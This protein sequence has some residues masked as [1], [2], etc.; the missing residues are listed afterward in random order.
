MIKFQVQKLLILVKLDSVTTLTL[1]STDLLTGTQN[2]SVIF[3]AKIKF[4]P[5]FYLLFQERTS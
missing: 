1:K 5:F 3:D 4:F 2:S